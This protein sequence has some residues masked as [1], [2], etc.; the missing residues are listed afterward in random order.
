M[1]PIVTE[2]AWIQ[3]QA[4]EPKQPKS[5]LSEVKRVQ[6]GVQSLVCRRQT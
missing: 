1:E 3:V 4:T 6:K 2:V 5:K